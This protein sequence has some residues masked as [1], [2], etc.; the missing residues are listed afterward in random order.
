M[1]PKTYS[2]VF[3]LPI[4]FFALAPECERVFKPIMRPPVFFGFGNDKRYGKTA[5][6]IM[7]ILPKVL[8]IVLW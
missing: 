1:N 2:A 3:Y 8:F 6:E 4:A 5:L 7:E